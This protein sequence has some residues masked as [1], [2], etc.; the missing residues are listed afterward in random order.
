MLEVGSG[1][2]LMLAAFHR[3]GWRTLGI[4][5]NKEV[6]DKARRTQGVE[7]VI[8]PVEA[9]PPD[10][11]FDLIVMFHVLEHIGEPVALLRECAKRLTPAGRLVA[12]VPN[13]ASWQAQFAGP[14]WL[15]LDPPRHLVHF[16]PKTLTETLERAGLRLVEIS[17]TSPE[18]DPY[19]WVESTIN[20]LTGRANTLTRF[21]MGLDPFGPAVLLS[22]M[23]G[24]VLALP[25]IL[26][27][28]ASWLAQRGA[29]MEVI[30][31]A[32]TPSHPSTSS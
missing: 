1:L 32:S 3:R 30:A 26:L 28:A 8:T 18:H 10:M 27:A 20:R 31:T 4:E 14:K 22:L 23:F 11:R 9:L 2:G 25:A 19:G 5:R 21:L 16:T 12:N 17:Y 13:F 6:A 7:V 24:I 29:L 15:H